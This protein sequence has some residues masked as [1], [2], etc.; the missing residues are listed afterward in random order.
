MIYAVHKMVKLVDFHSGSLHIN[1]SKVTPLMHP[2]LYWTVADALI[3]AKRQL[4]RIS[5]IPDKLVTS[6][7]QPVLFVVLFH[8][9]F[10]R[11]IVVP[12]TSY[13]L[14][15]FR[16]ADHR[17]TMNEPEQPIRKTG[18]Q[19]SPQSHQAILEATLELF[20]EVGLQGL[21]I[22]AIAARAGVGK[23]TIY[24]HWSS[25]ED[26]INNE[27]GRRKAHP[28]TVLEVKRK[29]WKERKSVQNRNVLF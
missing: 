3:L 7:L 11:A 14:D 29:I 1:T 22:E 20:A 19:R 28:P 10:G 27:T 5:R 2:A 18:R 8:Y 13:M 17:K 26:I 15:T 6:A 12:G 9:V 4:L 23:T 16:R 21:S 25:K 24:R